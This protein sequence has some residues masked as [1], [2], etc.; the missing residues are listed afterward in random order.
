MEGKAE[1][2]GLM[3]FIIV[4]IFT[5]DII[6]KGLFGFKLFQNE[7]SDT[8]FNSLLKILVCAEIFYILIGKILT[9]YFAI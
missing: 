6:I 3:V 5:G 7:P 4:H 1:A 8:L 9:I 2:D